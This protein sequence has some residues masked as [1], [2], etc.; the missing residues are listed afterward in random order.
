MLHVSCDLCGKELRHGDDQRYVV[1][2]EIFAAQDPAEITD[3]DLD[4]DHMEAVSQLLRDME[5]QIGDGEDLD[6][7]HHNFRFDLCPECRRKFL[8][9]PLG[10]DASQ[11]FDFSEN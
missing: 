1:K 6:P 9:D 11:K 10:K 2:I 8:R 5:E 7:A 4:E 3:A